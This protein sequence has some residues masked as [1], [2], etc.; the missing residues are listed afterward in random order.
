LDSKAFIRTVV[1]NNQ[2]Q[3]YE[4][5]DGRIVLY[6]KWNKPLPYIQKRK[7]DLYFSKGKVMTMDIETR[8]LRRQDV[9]LVPTCLGLYDDKG[10]KLS[11]IFKEED[12][13]KEMSKALKMLM[14]KKY[15]G[16]VIYMH[17]GSKFDFTFILDALADL[18]KVDILMR[19]DNKIL[20]VKWTF[21]TIN[22]ITEKPHSKPSKII[23]FD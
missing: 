1:R 21:N 5:K 3:I 10:N 11:Y 13:R 6:Q 12:S 7:P 18:G 23:F 4:Y 2:K 22:P 16:K 20:Q 19:K 15:D 8:R 9:D 14:L 17:N